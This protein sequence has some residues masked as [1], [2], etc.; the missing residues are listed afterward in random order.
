M[1]VASIEIAQQHFPL[2][3]WFYV[4]NG[5]SSEKW[6]QTETDKRISKPQK[7]NINTKT[8]IYDRLRIIFVQGS[9]AK[10]CIKKTK[11]TNEILYY[12]YISFSDFSLSR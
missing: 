10:K 8:K 12:N 6:Y 4:D 5:N 3:F 7:Y 11:Q 1:Y 9:K 2:L